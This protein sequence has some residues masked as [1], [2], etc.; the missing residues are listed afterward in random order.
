MMESHRLIQKFD[1]LNEMSHGDFRVIPGSS[2]PPE[3]E[4][5]DFRD[6]L[7]NRR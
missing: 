1:L 5:S 6:V 3:A 7:R 4:R 2:S